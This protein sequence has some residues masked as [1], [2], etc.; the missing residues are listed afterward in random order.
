M[1]KLPK[2]LIQCKRGF[3]YCM[4]KTVFLKA[5]CNYFQVSIARFWL[6]WY[7]VMYAFKATFQNLH[8]GNRYPY[9]LTYDSDIE[10]TH[11]SVACSIR[12]IT[13]HQCVTNFEKVPWI[14]FYCANIGFNPA[15]GTDD[16]INN[17]RGIHH[18]VYCTSIG[19]HAHIDSNVDWT[20][21]IW[22]INIC[23]KRKEQNPQ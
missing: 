7:L 11:C 22:R 14:H 1:V 5:K 6:W 3:R 20:Q 4:A 23:S 15:S 9:T 10:A 21:Y 2:M 13:C 8:S 17:V 12:C 18:P 19:T 16:T